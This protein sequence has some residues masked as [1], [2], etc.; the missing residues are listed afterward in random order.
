MPNNLLT[1]C[2]PSADPRFLARTVD[3]LFEN[4][5]GEVEVIVSA[6]GYEPD[7]RPRQGLTVLRHKRMGMR[8]TLN[9]ARPHVR[10]GWYMKTDEHCL[11]AP[12]YDEILKADCGPRDV[13]IPRRYSLD[14]EN[15]CIERNPKGPRDA[16]YLS[17]PVWSIRE[18]HDYSIN[19]LEWA[20]RTRALAK[21]WQGY[22]GPLAEDAVDETMSWQGSFYMMSR[23][24]WEFIGP[25]EEKGWGSFASE[26]QVVGLMTQLSGG[27]LLLSKRCYYAHLYKGKR[28][29]RGYRPNNDEIKAG[30]EFNAWYWMT[31][32]WAG[33]SRNMRDFIE[34]WWPVPDWP[35]DT[36]E[37]WD[38]YF[39]QGATLEQLKERA[40][41]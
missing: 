29:G 32:Q 36:L 8:A 25:L 6:D 30:H 17:S 1:V 31:D 26:P 2:I 20:Q 23:D 11:F 12:G 27:R 15:W 40:R 13:I 35:A 10:G 37:R 28:Y 4:A 24:Q 14:A 9:A 19:G 39:P 7:L 34:Q 33:R 16:H 21:N 38:Y 22:D 18:R 5:A 3:G 41:G